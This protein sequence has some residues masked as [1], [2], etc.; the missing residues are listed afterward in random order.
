M[1]G[2]HVIITGAT[3]GIGLETARA[4]AHKQAAVTLI[5]RN[6]QKLADTAA[7][8]SDAAQNRNIDWIQADLSSIASAQAAGQQFL[9]KHGRLD[10]LVNNAGAYFSTFQES[11]DGIEMTIALN[12]VGPFVL[13][14]TLLPM[15]KAT[16]VDTGDGRI[17]NV[18]S[19]AHRTTRSINWDDLEGREKFSA[20]NAYGL[21]KAMNVLHANALVRRLTGSNVTANSLHPGAVNTN[22]GND[23]TGFFG[24][25]M[26]IAKRFM[27]SVEQGAATNI[28]L[29]AD[30]A[31]KGITGKYWAKSAQKKP[32]DITL[33]E[34]AQEK[35][36]AISEQWVAA[37]T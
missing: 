18:S 28:Y 24:W 7:Q 1:N 37:A 5:S 36:W 35:L 9:D 3:S 22:F 20:F 2:K 14:N 15:L 30:P 29:A 21:S 25:L 10:V 6:A 19:D 8:L 11:V 34:A 31:V 32:T 13:T 23:A 26:P 12:H 4:I 16:A 17:V 33:D 27:I